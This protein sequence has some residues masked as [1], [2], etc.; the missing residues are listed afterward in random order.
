VAR[1]LTSRGFIV[2]TAGGLGRAHTLV[3]MRRYGLVVLDLRLPDGSGIEFLGELLD[4]QPTLRVL[5]LSAITDVDTRVRCLDIGAVDFLT[6]PFSVTEL[7]ARAQARLREPAA[8]PAQRELR[9]GPLSLDLMLRRAV[10]PKGEVSLSDREFAVLRYLMTLQGDVASR[11]E[12][13]QDIWGIV[14]DVKSNVVDVCIGR[15]RA[16]LGSNAIETVRHVGYRIRV[17]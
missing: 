14:F 7:V 5:V 13:Q 17:P 4:E 9:C 16:K 2:D 10:G 15:L 3:R 1:A 8:G 11:E 6:K 12:L